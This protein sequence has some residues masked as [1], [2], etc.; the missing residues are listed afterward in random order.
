MFAASVLI[1]HAISAMSD[2]LY[3]VNGY[4]NRSRVVCGHSRKQGIS[5][6]D[7]VTTA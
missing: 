6:D 5:Q 3:I 7:I 2:V 4:N 1:P